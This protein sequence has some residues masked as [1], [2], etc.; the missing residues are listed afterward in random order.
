VKR[1]ALLNVHGPTRT[2]CE[3]CSHGHTPMSATASS[4][5]ERVC[6]YVGLKGPVSTACEWWRLFRRRTAAVRSQTPTVLRAVRP[7]SLSA[8]LMSLGQQV[9]GGTCGSSSLHAAQSHGSSPPSLLQRPCT[10]AHSWRLACS[11]LLSVEWLFQITYGGGEPSRA[12]STPPRPDLRPQQAW[13]VSTVHSGPRR[14]GR[15][16]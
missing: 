12:R 7:L 5:W 9:G 14:Q 15:Q 10:P 2:R 3:V 8:E 1:I 16:S 11:H 6:K 4:A 13:G